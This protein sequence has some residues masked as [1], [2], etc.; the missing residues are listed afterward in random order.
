MKKNE[1]PKSAHAGNK[2]RRKFCPFR[3]AGA[4]SID[5]KDVDLLKNYITD[6]GKIVPSRISGISAP[7]QRML[8]TAVKRARNLALL[9]YSE[10]FVSPDSNANPMGR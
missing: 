6:S 7:F 10:G 1:R 9:S 8:K 4:K 5:Y 2:N 3:E